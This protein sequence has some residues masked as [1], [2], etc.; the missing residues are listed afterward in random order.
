MSEKVIMCKYCLEH[1][2]DVTD[3]LLYGFNNWGSFDACPHCKSADLQEA[4]L[5][6]TEFNALLK[7]IRANI[8]NGVPDA[9]DTPDIIL[10]Y[11]QLKA[12]N[13][14]EFNEKMM[15]IRQQYDEKPDISKQQPKFT[16]K[17]PTCGSPNIKKISGG[18]RWLGT[19]LFGLASSDIGK[20][21]CCN[22]CGYKW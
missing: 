18:K 17:C 14:Q 2:K 19:G 8:P 16:P 7:S 21:M 13:F 9:P 6:S 20:T 15:K 4:N 22:S 1:E 3:R 5:T 10:K 12:E 11:N